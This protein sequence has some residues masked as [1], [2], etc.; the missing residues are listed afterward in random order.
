M[1]EQAGQQEQKEGEGDKKDIKKQ[2][3]LTFYKIFKEA[4]DLYADKNDLL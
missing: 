4:F 1:S 2:E 3:E